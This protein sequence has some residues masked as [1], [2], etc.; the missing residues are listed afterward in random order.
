MLGSS[1]LAMD[2]FFSRWSAF[3]TRLISALVDSSLPQPYPSIFPLSL[4]I[5]ESA[6]SS[7]IISFRRSPSPPLFLV[8]GTMVGG[9]RGLAREAQRW[10]AWPWHRALWQWQWPGP[11]VDKVAAVGMRVHG[12]RRCGGSGGASPARGAAPTSVACPS[13][14]AWP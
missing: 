5:S 14:R 6:T 3:S 4:S 9:G 11:G 1:Q 2:I 12:G 10:W 13:V 7:Y 8:R